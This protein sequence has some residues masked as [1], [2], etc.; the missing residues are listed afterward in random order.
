MKS[1]LSASR[2]SVLVER[3]S[4]MRTVSS[5]SRAR[6]SWS[7][8]GLSLLEVHEM[9]RGKPAFAFAHLLGLAD[10]LAR[11]VEPFVG[12]LEEMLIG[13]LAEGA[14]G[15]VVEHLRVQVGSPSASCPPCGC[16][17][18]RKSGLPRRF[19]ACSSF[20]RQWSGR[21]VRPWC[22]RRRGNAPW[23]RRA[24]PRPFPRRAAFRVPGR[25]CARSDSPRAEA[26][27]WVH[28]TCGTEYP[29]RSRIPSSTLPTPTSRRRLKVPTRRRASG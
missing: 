7:R 18:P 14:V 9:R 13:L 28:R 19:P 23:R 11:V 27:A 10:L 15:E 6:P 24:R 29:T 17:R 1:A 8:N 4:L 12:D 3:M 26:A 21:G 2:P 20:R 25:R 5:A 16:T 22:I